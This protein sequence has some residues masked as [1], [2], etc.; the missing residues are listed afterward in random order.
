MG[1][2]SQL[3][4]SH[5]DLLTLRALGFAGRMRDRLRG[6]RKHESRARHQSN[7]SLE[8]STCVHRAQ[9]SMAASLAEGGTAA[10]YVALSEHGF[11]RCDL[12]ERRQQNDIGA[13]I[14]R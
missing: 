2:E 4:M 5:R 9:P 3:V 10:V 1:I 8:A 6:R 11:A 13:R 7:Q 12:G 14:L